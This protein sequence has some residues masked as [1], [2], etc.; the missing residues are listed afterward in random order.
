MRFTLPLLVL[1]IFLSGCSLFGIATKG[2]LRELERTH[3]AE[4]E[5]LRRVISDIDQQL[6]DV[7]QEIT[8]AVANLEVARQEQESLR[9]QMAGFEGNLDE[10][11]ARAE[12]AQEQS[13]KALRAHLQRLIDERERLQRH[14]DELDR[15]IQNWRFEV[16]SPYREPIPEREPTADRRREQLLP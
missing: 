13:Q 16:D 1:G 14:L 10:V 8:A 9:L 6:G 15:Q 4:R 5:N 11:S 2:E 7:E 12:L 3:E